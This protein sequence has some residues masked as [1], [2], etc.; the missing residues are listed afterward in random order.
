MRFKS[1]DFEFHD[2]FRYEK[3]YPDRPLSPISFGKG[4]PA[5]ILKTNGEDVKVVQECLRHAT[6]RVT[7]DVYTQAVTPAKREAQRKVVEQL[8]M[9]GQQMAPCG[10]EQGTAE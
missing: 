9:S 5:T 1:D 7:L 3:K 2:P 4:I 10:P 8:A 6:C